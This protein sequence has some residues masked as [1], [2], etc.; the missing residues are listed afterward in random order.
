MQC[1]YCKEEIK[2]S[3]LKC[4]FCGSMLH[5]LE[6]LVEVEEPSNVLG[7]Y[8]SAFRK[9][10][11]F[12]GRARRREYWFFQLFNWIAIFLLAF[13]VSFIEGESVNETV[14][15]SLFGLY[16][17]VVLVPSWTLTV[18]RLHDI[19]MSGWWL[20]ITLLPFVGGVALTV[21]CLIDSTPGTNRYGPNPKGIVG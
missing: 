1:P 6:P 18:R 13:L 17:L 21:F 12:S 16:F 19:N 8:I 20:L 9:F 11:E 14:G 10:G 5:A 2:E 4:R 3:A 15:S 7:Y